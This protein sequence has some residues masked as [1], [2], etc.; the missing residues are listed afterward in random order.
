MACRPIRRRSCFPERGCFTQVSASCSVMS[1]SSAGRIPLGSS[2]QGP[3]STD[4]FF[5]SKA[6]VA[7]CLKFVSICFM[8]F[9]N[10]GPGI[11]TRGGAPTC[12]RARRTSN[13]WPAAA[14][15]RLAAVRLA[16]FAVYMGWHWKLMH[17]SGQDVGHPGT[18]PASSGRLCGVRG[19]SA[20]P[21]PSSSDSSSAEARPLC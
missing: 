18:L 9:P 20:P 17:R 4:E 15:V 1:H 12:E 21:R 11:S 8:Y 3:A 6:P 13:D 19:P 2:G 7:T 5:P 14:A 16:A 10:T